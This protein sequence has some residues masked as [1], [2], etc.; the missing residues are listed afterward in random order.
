MLKSSPDTPLSPDA[1]PRATGASKGD[2]THTTDN[3]KRT[4]K[5]RAIRASARGTARSRAAKARRAGKSTR[6]QS[7]AVTSSPVINPHPVINPSPARTPDQNGADSKTATKSVVTDKSLA[8]DEPATTASSATSPPD[9]ATETASTDTTRAGLLAATALQYMRNP[10]SN[11]R[12]VAKAWFVGRKLRWWEYRQRVAGMSVETER[13]MIRA[14]DIAMGKKP[15]E[16]MALVYDYKQHLEQR[17]D[18]RFTVVFH[19]VWVNHIKVEGFSMS[20]DEHGTIIDFK[21]GIATRRD[22]LLFADFFP[23][24]AVDNIW[25]FN[26]EP[27][28]GNA[29]KPDDET[30]PGNEL[31]QGDKPKPDKGTKSGDRSNPDKG[32]KSGDDSKSTHRPNLN[33]KPT[34]N[35]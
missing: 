1:E 14:G 24:K 28:F 2:G 23:D 21:Q 6:R 18:G 27:D 25:L 12:R 13:E 22:V 9:D 34:A 29:T 10:V 31:K 33:G 11:T 30:K 19:D 35:D 5:S 8:A 32:H 15:T 7:A 20:I 3:A 17:P 26:Y 4:R 16:F